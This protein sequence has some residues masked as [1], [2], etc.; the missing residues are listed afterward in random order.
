MGALPMF[1]FAY[2]KKLFQKRT[3]IEHVPRLNSPGL[4]KF[5]LFKIFLFGRRDHQTMV[6]NVSKENQTRNTYQ[7][8]FFKRRN[9]K[10]TKGE[11]C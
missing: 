5:T 6:E 1:I 4:S 8:I 11:T 7:V 3:E 2:K 9:K 10:K